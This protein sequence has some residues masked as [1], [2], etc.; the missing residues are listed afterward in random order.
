MFDYSIRVYQPFDFICTGN[1]WVGLHGS[2]YT[3]PWLHHWLLVYS[4]RAIIMCIKASVIIKI[5]IKCQQ[6]L[7]S[8][9]PEGGHLTPTIPLDLS[10][11]KRHPE[12]SLAPAHTKQ[13]TTPITNTNKRQRYIWEMLW[14]HAHLL[15]PSR[16]P[17]PFV[18]VSQCYA[19]PWKSCVEKQTWPSLVILSLFC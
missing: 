6:C 16:G 4:H 5:I 8:T 7:C 19:R 9:H 11:V 15:K 17:T 13:A 18:L 10:W 12:A 14:I 1:F 2:Y 3:H